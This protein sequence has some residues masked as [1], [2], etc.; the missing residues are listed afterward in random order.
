LELKQWHLPA[1][2]IATNPKLENGLCM[3]I[4]PLLWATLIA[5]SRT[6]DFHHHW[7]GM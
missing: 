5:A 6:A 2:Y 4:I 3:V 7:Q 1:M